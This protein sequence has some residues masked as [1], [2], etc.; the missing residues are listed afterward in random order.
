MSRL[1]SA[2]HDFDLPLSSSRPDIDPVVI[3]DKHAAMCSDL[4]Q[5]G[6]V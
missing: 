2:M 1:P 4:D 5:Y 3:S 6:R